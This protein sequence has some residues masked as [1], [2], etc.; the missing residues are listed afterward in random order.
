VHPG[1]ARRA[2]AEARTWRTQRG[3]GRA[4][5]RPAAAPRRQRFGGGNDDVD[6]KHRAVGHGVSGRPSV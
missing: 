3:A 6:A 5:N 4:V 2:A 1:V